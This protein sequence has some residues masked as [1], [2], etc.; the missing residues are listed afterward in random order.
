MPIPSDTD[1]FNRSRHQQSE[2][3]ENDFF[4][5]SKY[6]IKKCK[7]DLMKILITN[8]LTST[9]RKIFFAF[10]S[11]I[12]ILII[13]VYLQFWGS[14]ILRCFMWYVW[15]GCVQLNV[16]ES[17]K[18]HQRADLLLIWAARVND[19]ISWWGHYGH[20]ENYLK[21]NA[22]HRDAKVTPHSRCL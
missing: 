8:A 19:L 1:Y 21:Q 22:L 13:G 9:Q 18:P 11:K 12:I 10:W 17:G 6:F 4:K 3:H 2:W 15:D 5:V 16:I 20:G 14:N 7:Q